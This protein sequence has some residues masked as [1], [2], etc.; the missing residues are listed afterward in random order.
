MQSNGQFIGIAVLL[1]VILVMGTAVIWILSQMGDGDT[2][3]AYALEDTCTVGGVEVQCRGEVDYTLDKES[4]YGYVYTFSFE[5]TYGTGGTFSGRYSVIVDNTVG[6]PPEK[7]FTEDPVEKGKWHPTNA[8]DDSI[9]WMD[10]QGR[11][12]SLYTIIDGV[13]LKADLV[14]PEGNR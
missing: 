5:G 1:V 11:I 3:Y 8:S 13:A 2:H 4:Q 7:L 12:A 10:P 14:E 6:K 9:V